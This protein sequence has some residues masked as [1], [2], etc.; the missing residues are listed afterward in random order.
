MSKEAKEEIARLKSVRGAFKGHCTRDIELAERLLSAGEQADES[1]LKALSG[2]LDRRMRDVAEKDSEIQK[3]LAIDALEK[4]IEDM[5]SFQDNI[6]VWQERINKFLNTGRKL[7]VRPIHTNNPTESSESPHKLHIKLPVISIKTFN[8]NPLQWQTFWDSFNNAINLNRELSAIEKMTYLMGLLEGE[9]ARAISGLPLTSDNYARAIE[10]LNERF[11]RTQIIISAHMDALAKIHPPNL[12]TKHLREFYDNCE[13][14]IRGLES[15]GVASET[16]GSLLIPILLKKLP[17]EL[18][19]LLFRTHPTADSN[20]KELRTALKE[21]IETR[22]KGYNLTS[23]GTS[24]SAEEDQ[25]IP[26]IDALYTGTY[27]RQPKQGNQR[28]QR[29]KSCSY[30]NGN[31]PA[32]RC[33]KVATVAERREFLHRHKRC[34]NCLGVNHIKPQCF[35]KNR[36]LKCKKKHHTSICNEPEQQTTKREAAKPEHQQKNEPEPLPKNPPAN[37]NKEHVGVA[38][39]LNPNTQIL[40]Q[41]AIAQVSKHPNGHYHQARLLFDTGSHRTFITEDMRIKLNLEPVYKESLHVATFG[42]NQSK[43]TNYDVVTFNLLSRKEDIS[44]NALV[45]TTICPPLQNTKNVTLPLEFKHLELA[46]PLHSSEERKVDIL[47]GSDYYTHLI[48]GKMNQSKDESLLATESK[49]GWLLSGSI[50]KTICTNHPPWATSS[51][52]IHINQEDEKL[53]ELL[54]KF[55]EVNEIPEIHTPEHENVSEKFLKTIHFDK[56]SGTYNVQLPWKSNKQE[57]PTNFELSKRRLKS[58]IFTLKTKDPALISKYNS[59]LMEQLDLGFIEKVQE[60]TNAT[61]IHYIPHFPVFKDSATTKMRIVYDASAK[62]SPSALCLND[63]LYTGP[64]LIQNLSSILIK[65][66]KHKVAFVA[67]M[68][69]AF[70][71]I[72]LHQNDRDAT[73]FLWLKDINKSF[74]DGQHSDIQIPA[75]TLWSCTVAIPI[76]RYSTTSPTQ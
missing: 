58:L 66:R 29:P 14:N 33:D 9:A 23:P 48:T 71:Q 1:E 26:T 7:P 11:G 73:R 72:A 64:N 4:D 25:L 74:D 75:R 47:I 59:Q 52:T 36:C 2:R 35:S 8:G 45:T 19:C 62:T 13:N 67:D 12:D 17:A 27:Q 32:I 20:L 57:L 55:W 63:C 51:Y 39:A 68:E 41:S 30:C 31:H 18:C 53:D 69:K 65:F 46:E 70:L 21:E 5:L 38:H 15:L 40:M 24:Q 49:V 44:I 6:S 43:K 56:A 22:E 76:E 16:Y 50:P 28:E 37:A 42:S 10:L 3:G 61:V 54:A 60:P 34:F